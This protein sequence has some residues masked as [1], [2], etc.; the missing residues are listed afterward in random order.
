M[1]GVRALRVHA[2]AIARF[3]MTKEDRYESA[4]RLIDD[5]AA[6]G[7]CA[8]YI[9]VQTRAKGRGLDREVD[10]LLARQ[11]VRDDVSAMCRKARKDRRP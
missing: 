6:S 9:D 5:L 3:G 8:D 7:A 4:R 1:C 11:S 2:S 10:G